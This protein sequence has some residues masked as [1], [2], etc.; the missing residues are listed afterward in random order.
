[1]T[2]LAC[3]IALLTACTNTSSKSDP[4]K[5]LGYKE[6]ARVLSPDAK[7]EAVLIEYN[8]GATTPF[9]YH[10]FIVA[11]GGTPSGQ[12]VLRLARVIPMK[13]DQFPAVRWKGESRVFIFIA[14][15]E[16]ANSANMAY[17]PDGRRIGV[18]VV[19]ADPLDQLPLEGEA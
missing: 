17:G 5:G 13:G 8:G 4:T 10:L 15:G 9:S 18:I 2:V 11:R 3:I 12:A 19:F 16:F 1:M 6:V 14:K 7:L